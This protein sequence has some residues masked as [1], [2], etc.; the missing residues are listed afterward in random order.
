MAGLAFIPP[1]IILVLGAGIAR[2]LTGFRREG[3]TLP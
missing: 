2:A 3:T 1:L